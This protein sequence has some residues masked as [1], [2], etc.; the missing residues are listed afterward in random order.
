MALGCCVSQ[1]G[2]VVVLDE[3][4]V[5]QAEAMV[6]SAAAGDGVFLKPPPAG[7]GFARVENS[8]RSAFDGLHELRGQRGNAGKSLDKIQRHALG[9]QNRAR[10]TG[11]V[12]QNVA[13]LTGWP[14]LASR[15]ILTAAESSGNAAS[16]KSSPATTSG[17][18]ACKTALAVAVSGMVASVVASPLPMSS[19]R[20]LDGLTDFRGGQ[21][22]AVRMKANGKLEK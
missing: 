8:R 3:H 11:N 5:E 18:R 14:S 10:R 21:F 1:R 20:A 16:A 2:E 19:A 22:H 7:R 17:S 12:Q 15:S 6:V 13:A 9:A 4:H